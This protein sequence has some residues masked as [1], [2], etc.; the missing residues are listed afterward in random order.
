MNN[1][2][3]ALLAIQHE[4]DKDV[5]IEECRG[6]PNIQPHIL[7]AYAQPISKSWNWKNETF[8]TTRIFNM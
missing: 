6:I 2:I 1:L 4:W 5:R 7:G 3:I 8:L